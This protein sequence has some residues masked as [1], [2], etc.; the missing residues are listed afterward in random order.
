[1][2]KVFNKVTSFCLAIAMCLGITAAVGVSPTQSVVADAATDYYAP[3]TAQGGTQLLGQLHDLITDSRS[4]YSSYADC[5]TYG[6]TT[7]PGSGSNTVM[8]FYTHIDISNS[9]WDVSG[10]WN[11]EHV[12][13]KSLSG[14]LWGTTGGGSDLHHIRPAEKDLN[15]HRASKK[16]G[17]VGSGGKEEYTSVSNVLGGHSNSNTFEPLDNVKGDVAR[18]VM[19]VY[20]HYNSYTYVGGTTN[21]SGGSGYFGQLKFTQVITASS[22][23]AAKRLLLEW[24]KLDP[25]DEIE[26]VRNEAVYKIQGNRNPFIDNSSYADAIWGDGSVTPP[27]PPAELQSLSLN[28][29]AVT[30]EKGRT[31]TLKATPNPANA[32]SGV[33]WS[34]SDSSVA[35]VSNGKITAKGEGTATITATSTVKPSVSA[36]ATI[37]V[38]PAT[39]PDGDELTGIFN[40]ALDLTA[41]ADIGKVLYFNGQMAQSYY[42]GT[43]ETEAA[44]AEVVVEKVGDGYTIE[45][46]GKYLECLKSGT[47]INVTLQSSSSGTWKFN[48]ELNTFTWGIDGTE[49]YLG[50][51]TNNGKTYT[52]ISASDIKYITGDNAA[53]VGVTQFIVDFVKVGG[54]TPVPPAELE[55]ITINPASVSLKVGGTRLLTVTPSPAN[56]EFAVNW[57]SSDTSVATVSADG[58]VTAVKEGTAIITATSKSNPS[59]TATA[60]VTVTK[61]ATDPSVSD[62]EAFR[63]AVA[64]IP[65]SGSLEVRRTAI[66]NAIVLYNALNAEDKASATAEIAGLQAAIDSYNVAVNSYNSAADSSDNSALKGAGSFLKGVAALIKALRGE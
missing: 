45:T 5:K 58:T 39:V 62:V 38:T 48:S 36:S 46:G 12:W 13:A 44:A 20:T 41:A 37:T 7:D 25:V 54:D 21:G 23:D 19:Y 34:S 60:T 61:D 65:A 16:Y 4:G 10:G 64:A 24:N 51:R 27:E 31:Y 56:A 59:I 18:I 17:E 8:E 9:K 28:T 47:H 35:T 1:M 3:V 55:S 30:L 53:N 26:R 52:T 40:I 57:T 14:N 63:E 6:K 11:R 50:T 15:N 33:T 2:K 42:F 43:T 22:E 66:N 29:T 32:P 49:Y